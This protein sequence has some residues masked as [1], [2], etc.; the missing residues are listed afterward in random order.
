[1]EVQ[2]EFRTDRFPKV[3]L[4]ATIAVISLFA[5]GLVGYAASYSTM[6]GRIGDLQSQ[7]QSQLSSIT[8]QNVTYLTGDGVS[9][10]A[11]YKQV[12]ESVV[13]IMGQ[14]VQYDVFHRAVYSTVQGS[15]FVCN[16]SG[17]L[18]VVTNYHVVEGASDITVTFTDGSAYAATVLG[19]DPYEDLAVLATSAP[20]SELKTL[21]VAR[22]STLEVGDPVVADGNPYG[23]AGSMTTG[24]VSALGRTITEAET[25]GYP[26]AA[27]IQTS[28]P[29]NPGNSGGPLLNYA[30][31]VVGITTAI[32]SD[33]TGV[34][35]AIPSNTILREIGSL[36]ATGGYAQHPSLGASGV[37]MSYDIAKA[38]GSNITYGWLVTSVS[39]SQSGLH[40]GTSK[41]S[42]AG[43]SVTIGGDIMIAVNGTRIR[44]INDLSTYLEENT[45]PGTT[46]NT[47][48]VRSNQVII[49][50]VKLGTRSTIA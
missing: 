26:I 49:I 6:V 22:S 30:G 48:V 3:A 43:A 17:Q 21:A 38:M 44:G 41:V 40:G 11:L 4:I 33:S 23:L 31:E 24:I 12:Q 10:S 45:L 16:S 8:Y 46:V 13:I 9:L 28:A 19:Q 29:I 20:A 7:L 36:I 37:D 35:F 47:T 27:A 1:L 2:Q 42:I 39:S 32:V 25:G 50:P 5:G 34:G 18:V 14:V 15:G